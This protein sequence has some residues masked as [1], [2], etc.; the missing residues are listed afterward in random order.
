MKI[1]CAAFGALFLSVVLA[2]AKPVTIPNE[3]ATLDIPDA[4][5]V[6]PTPAAASATPVSILTARS[7]DTN[8]AMAILVLDNSE[9]ISADNSEF[10]E[11]VR[12]GIMKTAT[13]QN[14]TVQF[15][16]NAMLT[17]GGVPASCVQYTQTAAGGKA[18]S[19]RLY[20]F[21]ANGKMYS[22]VFQTIDPAQDAALVV[23]ANSLKFSTPP[24][25]PSPQS[26]EAG[27]YGTIVGAV[28][29]VLAAFVTLRWIA[30]RKKT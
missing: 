20:E 6:K 18:V 3:S 16:P 1:L 7:P 30:R 28:V 26:D 10:V 14:T 29:G 9:G 17:L 11:G 19:C 15:Q 4:W 23:I 8:A 5:E 2:T 27:R 13:Q 24:T 25:L 22:L 12:N 21:A